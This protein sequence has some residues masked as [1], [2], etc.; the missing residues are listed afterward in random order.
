MAFPVLRNLAL[1]TR[2]PMA[3]DIPLLPPH[4]ADFE[5]EELGTRDNILESAHYDADQER[6]DLLPPLL[7]PSSRSPKSLLTDTEPAKW[8]PISL[9]RVYLF[10]LAAISLG[11]GMCCFAL[12]A[13]SQMHNGLSTAGSSG[14]FKFNEKFLPTLAAVMYALLW[15]PVVLDVIRTEPWELLSLPVGSRA[16]DSLL[17]RDKMWWSHLADAV[18]NRG[19]SGGVRWA[20]MISVVASLVAS[21][22]INPLSA[23]L[24]DTLSVLITKERQFSGIVPSTSGV[25]PPRIGDITYLRAVTNLLFNVSTS[26]WNTNEYTVA[27]FWPSDLGEAPM[28]ATLTRSPQLWRANHDVLVAQVQCRPFKTASNSTAPYPLTGLPYLHTDDGCAVMPSRDNSWC[29]G[30]IWGQIS[31]ISSLAAFG[32]CIALGYREYFVFCSRNV[33]STGLLHQVTYDEQK[34]YYSGQVC[35][36]SYLTANIPVNISTT[37]S[38]SMVSFDQELFNNAQRPMDGSY[39]N[40]SGFESKF[41]RQTQS[42]H[43][44]PTLG[45]GF[46]LDSSNENSNFEGP[47]LVLATSHNYSIDGLMQMD[48]VKLAQQAA[49]IKQRFL[50]EVLLSGFSD[51]A[52]V[53]KPTYFQGSVTEQQSRL[54]ADFGIGITIGIFFVLLAVAA[55]SLAFLVKLSKRPLQLHMDPNKSTTAAL[56]LSDTS[57]SACFKALDRAS[58]TNMETVLQDQSF[59]MKNGKLIRLDDSSVAPVSTTQ[60]SSHTRYKRGWQSGRKVSPKKHDPDWRSF[61]LRRRSGS[62]LVMLLLCVTAALIA[63]YAVSRKRPLYQ[64]AFVYQSDVRI[65]NLDITT[66]APYSIIPTLVA[67]GIKLWWTTIDSAYRRLSPFL[68]MARSPTLK[69]SQGANLS[70]MTTPILWIT[71]LALR[72]GHWLLA[73]V[74]F[75]TL[76]SEILQ[77]SM[78]ALWNREPGVL[79]IDISLTNQFEIRSVAHIFEDFQPLYRTGANIAHPKIAQYL[80]GGELYQTSWEYG[81]LAE[82]AFGASPPAWSKDGWNFPPVNI[83]D[84]PKSLPKLPSTNDKEAS[85][86]GLTSSFNITYDSTGLRARV[87]CIPIES[88]SRWVHEVKDLADIPLYNSSANANRPDISSGF[89]LSSEVRVVNFTKFEKTR[90]DMV[91]IGEWLHFNYSS[92]SDQGDPLYRSTNPHNFTVIWINASYPYLYQQNISGVPDNVFDLPPRLIFAERPQIQALNCEPIFETSKMRIVINADSGRVEDYALLEP[93]KTTEDA[94]A[95]NFNRHFSDETEYYKPP[96]VDTADTTQTFNT[97]VSWGYLFQLALLQACNVQGFVTAQGDNLGEGI[98]GAT[99]FSFIEPDLYSDPYSY[100]SLALVNYDR[101]SLL[102]TTTLTA[103]TQRVFSTFFQWFAS[104]RSGYKGDYWAYQ[105]LGAKLPPDLDFGRVESSLTTTKTFSRAETMCYS[106][107]STYETLYTVEDVTTMM[108]FSV[109]LCVSPT[110]TSYSVWTQ[111]QTYVTIA[112]TRT[113]S[114]SKLAH[115]TSQLDT[116]ASQSYISPTVTASAQIRKRA[117]PTDSP[118]DNRVINAKVSINRETL[119]ISPSA[120]FLS[121]SI[122]LFLI[123]STLV[124]YLGQH[125]QFRLLPRDFDSPASLFAAV[126]A[127]EKLKAWGKR[128]HEGSHTGKQYQIDDDVA[129]RMGYFTGVDGEEHWGIEVVGDHPLLLGKPPLGNDPGADA[130]K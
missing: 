8:L 83:S 108:T 50:G 31:N 118:S 127:S 43:L 116:T 114:S 48:P 122:I 27:P 52:K 93:A 9:T 117:I 102:N 123:I 110:S 124:I 95:E 115:I 74:T 87:E 61:T 94:W 51:L 28:A 121:V 78:S 7:P 130:E 84:V 29:N 80:Y 120:L 57:A 119:V 56:A 128:Q 72:K 99:P 129:V 42:Y 60:T 13:Y 98:P 82:L 73:L 40:I 17:K 109:A 16:R 22:V 92:S 21:V 126:Y 59:L 19:R 4:N 39:L 75:G 81:S 91:A 105:S 10:T 107:M 3:N 85:S 5:L 18:Q 67:V 2:R 34:T 97:T 20:L 58:P 11:L 44:R 79:E 64:G 100:A 106:S 6:T 111:T 25:P 47:A 68:A 77:V 104:S 69:A 113:S 26:A 86:S 90:P 101:E 88:P 66:L 76:T 96:P 49:F 41:I 55:A 24:F 1:L 33:T 53:K 125:S 62:L 54:V 45:I 30:G 65:G 70:Y 71:L 103:V 15:N 23:G 12:V 32:K 112:D 89:E 36:T 14:G 38:G 46:G 35:S 37:S 63:V